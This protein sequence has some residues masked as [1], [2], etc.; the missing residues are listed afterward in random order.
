MIV[1]LTLEASLIS[2]NYHETS[3]K[4]IADSLDIIKAISNNKI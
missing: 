2:K 1:K 4:S 3:N